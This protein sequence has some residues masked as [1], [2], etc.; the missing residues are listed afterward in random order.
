MKQFG[1][2][3]GGGYAY[4]PYR[5]E[6]R[7]RRSMHTREELITILDLLK[8]KGVKAWWYSVSAKCSF[9]LF[10]SRTLPFREDAD[11]ELY[12]WLVSEAHLRGIALF[13]WEYL[14]TAP[15]LTEQHPEWRY[16]YWEEREGGNTPRDDQF[17]CHNS[18]YG[19][20][21]KEYCLEVVG[22]LGFDGIWFDGCYLHSDSSGRMA[23]R[24]PYCAE[25][26]LRESGREI[27]TAIDFRDPSFRRFIEWRYENFTDYWRSLSGYV[28]QRKPEAIVVFNYFN[29]IGHDQR[30]GSPLRRMPMEGMIASES[31][32]RP[33]QVLLQ[34]KILHALNDNYPTE[35]WDYFRDAAQNSAAI[36][37]PEPASMLFH[38]QCSAASG[39]FASFGFEAFPTEYAELITELSAALNPIA[40]YVGGVQPGCI[41]LVLSGATKDYAHIGGN[42]GLPDT[43]QTWKAVHG[44]HNLLNSLHLPSE[45]LLD[46]MLTGE[47]LSRYQAV[48]L[49]DVRC[50]S[51]A[52]AAELRHYVE[53]GGLL[54][55]TG[56]SGILDEWGELRDSGAGALDAWFGV[57]WR[58]SELSRPL[59]ALRDLSEADGFTR[60]VGNA[61]IDSSAG[62]ERDAAGSEALL[63]A[64]LPTRVM[65]SGASSL[66]RTVGCEVLAYGQY[67]VPQPRHSQLPEDAH[68]LIEG[69]AIVRR[70]A[71][72]GA[73]VWMAANI[74]AGYAEQ[75]SRRTREAVRSLLAERV[76]PPFTTDAPANV[77]VTVWQ[78]QERITFHLLNV[79]HSFLHVPSGKE[80]L[81]YPEDFTPTRP[82]TIE[83]PG[84]WREA[85]SP[86]GGLVEL[87]R[88]EG[89]RS[90]RIRLQCLKQHA[91]IALTP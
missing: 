49:P 74:G 23:C 54:L 16:V 26:Y 56:A 28:R 68:P 32:S 59:L 29:R 48:V 90:T 66:I 72:K 85:H 82:I 83:I 62:A 5:L 6:F 3:D 9:P 36:P 11:T 13:S 30:S 43:W 47:Y 81:M 69:E 53:Q 57:T 15:L 39:G 40:D 8:A 38:A 46:N 45:V 77:V 34:H 41:G 65:L 88:A 55:I 60:H 76:T 70:K 89:G 25:L 33:Y 64:G 27:P 7:P 4:T 37:E 75:P 17:I 91:V 86:S 14:N 61:E 50:L 44:M 51:D 52:S 84:V 58:D 20:M 22:D 67:R 73:A 18:P 63:R 80:T 79:P 87:T 10:E 19:E 78:Q 71:G 1:K 31:C 12:R 2:Q 21:L 42:D 24:C 35:I